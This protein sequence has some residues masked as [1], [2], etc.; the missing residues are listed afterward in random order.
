[1]VA[2]NGVLSGLSVSHHYADVETIAAAT[3]S[4]LET[5]LDRLLEAAPVMEAFVLATCNR[6]EYY[7]VTDTPGTGHEILESYLQAID[8]PSRRPM[9]HDEAIEHL[10]R[11][12]TGLESQVLGEDEIIG[13]VRES[14]HRSEDAGAIGP[15]LEPVLLKALHVGERA[16]SETAINEGV[17]SLAS[18]GVTCASEH[19]DLG[20][21]SVVVVGAG[22][23][24]GRVATDLSNRGVGGLTI[25]NRSRERADKLDASLENA[26]VET[27]SRLSVALES[28][29]VCIT[30]TSSSE[31]IITAP[32]FPVDGPPV[33]IDLG[34]PPDVAADVR[35]RD[36]IEYYNLDRLR[37]I[38]ERTHRRR[39]AAAEHVGELVEDELRTLQR[40]F[41]REQAAAVI[42]AM[43]SGADRIKRQEL[44][45]AR[46]RLEH[47]ES[48]PPAVL[49]DL[50]DALVNRLMA[51][52]T[53]GL[54][55]AAEDD[56]WSTISAAIQMFDPD[57]E[58]AD[59]PE[60]IREMA[61]AD[62]D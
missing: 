46:V 32:S 57:I 27:L 53:E 45:R 44:E 49:E 18:A 4:S 14:Y 10:F 61:L 55:D 52:P 33:V 2:I 9:T 3:P 35:D 8:P 21:A 31:P 24:G 29:D 12:T 47:G 17:V 6:A 16:R 20:E 25:V 15:V 38:T 54:R 1:M 11:V 43:R 59:L 36:G 40:N 7:V 62:D 50:A 5:A 28:A 22:S 23:T 34:Q 26:S 39:S 51:A 19:T 30:A 58:M 42:A 56:D 41:K 60:E 13:Q 37:T 48:P